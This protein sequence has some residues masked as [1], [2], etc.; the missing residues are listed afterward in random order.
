M[1]LPASLQ[2]G[3][4][5]PVSATVVNVGLGGA[6]V[7][8]QE[9]PDPDE[10]VVLRVTTPVLWDPLVVHARGAWVETD[11][12]GRVRAGLHFDH[13]RSRAIHALFEL[14]GADDFD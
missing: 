13:E 7:A 11:A 5:E 3:R 10:E 6:C 1:T 8:L 14:L 12:R 4:A 9:V 2:R